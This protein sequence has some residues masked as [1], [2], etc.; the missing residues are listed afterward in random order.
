M[1]KK[2][3]F[4]IFYDWSTQA[5]KQAPDTVIPTPQEL[6]RYAS[7]SDLDS[8]SDYKALQYW[9]PVLRR[10][11]SLAESGSIN[12]GKDLSPDFFDPSSKPEA[13]EAS[14]KPRSESRQGHQTPKTPPPVEGMNTKARRSQQHGLGSYGFE[15]FAPIDEFSLDDSELPLGHVRLRETDNGIALSWTLRSQ[16]KGAQIFRV[17]SSDQ[18]ETPRLEEAT[19]HVATSAREAEDERVLKTA[20]RHYEVW[21]NSGENESEALIS[22]PR[23]VGRATYVAPVELPKL[24][25]LDS[26]ISAQWPELPGTDMVQVYYTTAVG[27]RLDTSA[28]VLNDDQRYIT[29]FRFEPPL[30]GHT[31]RIAAKRFVQV[32]G[33]RIGS[34]L[35]NEQTVE[36][37]AKLSQ[38]D[39]SIEEIDDR[40]LR[41]RWERPE[42][43][44]VRIYRTEHELDP[45]AQDK[46]SLETK[47]LANYG[48]DNNDWVNHLDVEE[49]TETLVILPE[50][51]YTVHITIVNVVGEHARIGKTHPVPRVGEIGKARLV[52]RVE[53]QALSFGW[54][55]EASFVQVY[56]GPPGGPHE[57]SAVGLRPND[58][59]SHQNYRARGGLSLDLDSAQ[60]LSIAV[61]PTR[62]YAGKEISG[63]PKIINYPGLEKY[64]YDFRLESLVNPANPAVQ[65]MQELVLTVT[66]DQPVHDPSH[67]FV[68]VH[69]KGRIP[70]E[71]NDGEKIPT[72]QV[73]QDKATGYLNPVSYTEEERWLIDQSLWGN[74]EFGKDFLRLFL[75]ETSG[76]VSE[77]I[78]KALID[79]EPWKLSLA[80]FNQPEPSYEPPPQESQ[81]PYPQPILDEDSKQRKGIFGKLFGR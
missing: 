13:F 17:F 76:D 31:Y 34:R 36:V 41:V 24:D 16:L 35:S 15:D 14:P 39:F 11:R 65:P 56:V 58:V 79:P 44:I 57:T 21:M 73:G 3:L 80:A 64:R 54:P 4:R 5:R 66:A 9:A 18:D 32:G 25:Y 42:S 45:G 38:L 8:S 47:L 75:V 30:R 69:Q 55:R 63:S 59:I 33:E 70:L 27:E 22:Q 1:D 26:Y 49:R 77:A 19:M 60:A 28:N 78:P 43:G 61:Y 51:W 53:E 71:P 46:D 12:S 48:L 29:G 20:A 81:Q 72:I 50:F 68:L 37:G 74:F 2:D 52:E 7:N 6:A 23:F 62:I 67:Y 40:T 10:L